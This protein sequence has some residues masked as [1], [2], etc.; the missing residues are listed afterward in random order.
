MENESTKVRCWRAAIKIVY[1]EF[2]NIDKAKVCHSLPELGYLSKSYFD[3]KP[4]D[5]PHI[6]W[7]MEKDTLHIVG[8]TYEVVFG[9][10]IGFMDAIFADKFYSLENK[11]TRSFERS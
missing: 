4:L 8:L 5:I 9:F 3:D 11:K 7:E 1:D 10:V 6:S 2:D